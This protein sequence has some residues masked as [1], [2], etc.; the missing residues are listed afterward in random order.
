MNRRFRDVRGA[1]AFTMA[2]RLMDEIFVDFPNIDH[3]FIREFQTG[4][5]PRVLELV[6][7]AWL[8]EQGHRLDRTCPAPDFVIAG[9]KPVE[10]EV[11][12]S[13]PPENADPDDVDSSVG[14][15]RLVPDDLSA[16]RRAFVFQAGKSTR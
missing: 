2:R 6:V 3:S 8:T 16:A 14:L 15:Q 7:F 9:D 13:N 11:T 12:T 10:I 4:V 1:R 5:S